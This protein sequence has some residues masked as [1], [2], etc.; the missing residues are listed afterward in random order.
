MDTE[1]KFAMAVVR[2]AAQLARRIQAGMA[3]MNLT[4]GDL[5]PV[6]VADFALQ[7]LAGHAL[8]QS[9]PDDLLVAEERAADLDQAEPMLAA[10][11]RFLAP[12]VPEVT[13]G[14]VCAWIDRGGSESGARFWTLDPID[15]TK[16]YLRGGQYA[17][18]LALV[19]EGRVELGVLGCP[20]LGD[21]VMAAARRGHG[22]W[23]TPLDGEDA[24]TPLHVSD[25]RDAAAARLLRSFEKAHTNTE[26]I[27]RFVAA[28]GIQAPPIPMDS[29]A[30]YA[31][32]SAGKGELILRFL[33]PDKPDYRERIWDHAAGSI[34]V[35]EA[36]GRVTDLDGRPLDF[37]TG[38]TL[39]RNR[40]LVVSNGHLHD[41]ALEVLARITRVELM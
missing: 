41:M 29:Q 23:S 21:G 24:F 40:G 30:K 31:V 1:L 13:A 9:F 10:I 8:Q 2:D 18:A 4:K 11:T 5:S 7:A 19:I 12:V 25:C 34:I 38:R 6:T 37:T 27:D 33:S 20:S 32:L 14:R 15:G 35:E 17:V 39:E 22:A 26:Q 3:S 16:G 36:G 28:M